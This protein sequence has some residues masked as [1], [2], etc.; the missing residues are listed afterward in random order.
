CFDCALNGAREAHS[1]NRG[2]A[3]N[4]QQFRLRRLCD[5]CNGEIS[6]DFLMCTVCRQDTACYDLCLSCVLGRDAIDRHIALTSPEHVFRQVE[7][8]AINLT[9]LP[10]PFKS[11]EKWWCNVCTGELTTGFFHC[12]GCGSG[13][14]G[15]DICVHCADEGGLFRHGPAPFHRFLYVYPIIVNTEDETPGNQSLHAPP[16]AYQERYSY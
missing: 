5:F 16:P 1:A 10:Q 2:G 12:Q 13:S 3:H 4:F 9:K 6:S 7:W 15:F 14:R 8:G 11:S